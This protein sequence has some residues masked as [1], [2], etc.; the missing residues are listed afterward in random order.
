MNT[1]NLPLYFASD[2]EVRVAK[3]PFFTGVKES[4]KR[5]VKSAGFTLFKN[6]LIFILLIFI[7]VVC[8]LNLVAYAKVKSDYSVNRD[9]FY[10]NA[11]AYYNYLANTTIITGNPTAGNIIWNNATQ[12]SATQLNISN[13]TVNT[14]DIA[15]YLALLKKGDLFVIRDSSNSNN[16]QTW[17]VTADITQSTG[18]VQVPCILKESGGIGFTGFPNTTP[19][20]LGLINKAVRGPVES[21]SEGW[22]IFGIVINSLIAFCALVAAIF[23]LIDMIKGSKDTEKGV[24]KMIRQTVTGARLKADQAA[25]EVIS[26]AQID[27]DDISGS[28]ASL[29]T[30]VK[31]Q[32]DNSIDRYLNGVI[33]SVEE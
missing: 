32:I 10:V 13:T 30:A 28:K 20:L 24:R 1:I 9:N 27:P 33:A 7:V 19:I 26:N 6:I 11:A 29:L 14:I 3:N 18:Y 23:V 17:E 15:L 5:L 31:F 21:L 2:E 4:A 16:Y 8:I 25:E 22:L 12:I